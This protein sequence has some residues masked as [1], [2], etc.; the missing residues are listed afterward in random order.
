MPA[1]YSAIRVSVMKWALV[2]AFSS[3]LAGC[4][5]LPPILHRW[6]DLEIAT[7]ALKREGPAPHDF[8]TF[9]DDGRV[10]VTWNGRETSNVQWRVRAAWLEIDTDNDGTFK[11][12]LRALTWTKDRIVAV[13][14]T[15]K[16]SVWVRSAVVD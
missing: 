11:M 10:D 8:L 2:A 15:G 14:P 13:S 12:R 6:A 7:A 4:A 1:F 9:S 3:L 5:T 16:R